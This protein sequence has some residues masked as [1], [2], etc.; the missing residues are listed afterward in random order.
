MNGGVSGN[1]RGDAAED[2]EQQAFSQELARKAATRSA[3]RSADGGFAQAAPRACHQQIG[4]IRAPDEKHQTNAT[5]K[6]RAGWGGL[7]GPCRPEAE[8]LRQ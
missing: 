4:D 2:S 1:Q 8:K 5:R 3:E 7:R 6:G